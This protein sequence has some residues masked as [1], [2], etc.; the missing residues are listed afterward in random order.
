M[1]TKA[2]SLVVVTLVVVFYKYFSSLYG[3]KFNVVSVVA[4]PPK[5]AALILKELLYCAAPR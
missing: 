1:V 4:A 3:S 5:P 2:P